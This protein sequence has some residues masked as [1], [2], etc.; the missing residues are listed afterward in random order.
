[1]EFNITMNI[2]NSI[3]VFGRHV[4]SGSLVSGAY[5]SQHGNHKEL[6]TVANR[7]NN[8]I[9]HIILGIHSMNWI[10]LCFID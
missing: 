4:A 6:E 2:F 7:V 5:K 1:M 9:W 8:F 10:S 3:Q